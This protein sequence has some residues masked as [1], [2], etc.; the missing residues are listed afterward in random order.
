MTAY[1]MIAP[2]L[3]LVAW[4][5]VMWVWMYATRIPA[6]QKAKI[7]VNELSRTGA[8][9]ELPAQVTR[10][11][12]NYNHLHEQ[13]TL[14]YAVALAA[15]ASGVNDPIA[16]AIAWA[17]VAA[18]FVHSL[19]QATVNVI[20]LRFL[21]FVIASLALLALLVRVAELTLL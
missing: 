5:F 4:T 15:L 12:D 20:P 3:A 17:Y 18:R 14:F 8:K 2:V 13:P 1:G 11:A 10:V 9:L 21:L 7:D 19:L 16:I 6:M